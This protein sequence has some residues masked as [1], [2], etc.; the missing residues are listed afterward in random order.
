VSVSEVEINGG[1][2]DKPTLE[3]ALTAQA[4]AFESCY[5]ETAKEVPDLEGRVLVTYLF[6]KG[7]RK[8]VSASHAGLGAK[9][10]N[11]CF[12]NAA[13]NM[14]LEVDPSA[15]RSTLVVTF[16]MAKVAK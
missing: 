7:E 16:Q 15:E 12:H 6:V 4:D 9:T 8:S 14:K 11:P 10:I 5:A 13:S 3:T 2:L 1:G